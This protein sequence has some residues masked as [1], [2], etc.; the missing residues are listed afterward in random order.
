MFERE[1]DKL[2]QFQKLLK[3]D[4]KNEDLLRQALTTPKMGNESG[5]SHY[6]ILETLGDPVLKLILS[7]KLYNEKEI[8]PKIL[9]RKK[10]KIENDNTLSVIADKFFDLEKF[11]FK[12]RD[13]N[14]NGTNILADILEALCGALY[15]DSEFDI[16]LVENKIVDIFYDDCETL[17]KNSTIFQK[18]KLL[19]YLQ[20][21][22]RQIPNV[23]IKHEK[24]GPDHDLMWIAKNPQIPNLNVKLPLD[25]K[26]KACRSKKEAEQDLYLKILNH[27]KQK[28]NV[29]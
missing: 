11:I 18:S 1:K 19:E 8:S 12:A 16:L 28:K 29:S 9:T 17:V 7:L 20:K 21:K 27:L 2:V 24:S 26:S 23:I 15:I 25:L 5:R 14:I 3:Y 4:F 22:Y 10:Q 13:Q 6:D